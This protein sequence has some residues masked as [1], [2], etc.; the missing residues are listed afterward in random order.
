MRTF[1]PL[2]LCLLGTPLLAQ[3]TNLTRT[4]RTIDFEERRLGNDEDLPMNFVKVEGAGFPHYLSG[5]LAI[6]RA[7]SPGHSFRFDLNGGSLLY[8]Y[9][10]KQI[11][12]TPGACYRVETYVQTT[13]MEHARARVSAYYVD[14]LARP[15]PTSLRHSDLFAASSQWDKDWHKLALD[16]P[17]APP[18]AAYLVL[19]LALLQPQI[20]ATSTLGDRTL[21]PQDIH[22]T[23]WFD[24]ISI[25]HI[26][27]V[28]LSSG[29]PGNIFRRSEPIA[30]SMDINDAF[31]EDLSTQLFVRDAFGKTVYQRSGTQL[32]ADDVHATHQR[33]S[34]PLP[35]LP[36]GWYEIATT[37]VSQGQPLDVQTLRVVRLPD[38]APPT[39]PD[40]RFGLIA[41]DLP[42]EKWP[43]LGTLLPHLGVGRV[44]LGV[45]SRTADAE[46]ADPEAFDATLAKLR[47]LDIHPTACLLELPPSL[48]KKLGG[49]VV[50]SDGPTPGGS[51]LRILKAAK[52]SDW[53]APLEDLLARHASHLDRWQLG[54]DG[55][56]AFVTLSG[57]R[58]VYAKVRAEFT[59]LIQHPDLAMPW[60]AWYE[61]D[62]ASMPATVALSV[63]ATVLPPQ[64]P[65]YTQ[66]LRPAGEH[67]HLSLSLQLLDREHYGRDVQVRDLAQR[68]IFALA[69]GA[70][71][72][73]LPA[74][75][76]H[77]E[78]PDDL[79]PIVHTLFTTLGKA[80]YVG[81]VPVADNVEAFLF[82]KSG[83][84]ILALWDN[85]RS[86]A[87]VHSLPINLGDDPHMTDIYGND[88]PLLRTADDPNT[89][90]VQ[91]V[92][93][94]M[95]AFLTNIDG[96]LAQFRAS[97]SLDNPLIESTFAAHTRRL[98]FKNTYPVTITGSLKI[99]PPEGW[100]ITPSVQTIN[101]AAGESFDREITIEFPVSSTAGARALGFDFVIQ[102][103]KPNSVHFHMPLTVKLG[104][105]D[106]GMQTIAMR[107]GDV[108]LIQQII[109]NYSDHPVDYNAFAMLPGQQRQER[110]V[111]TLRPGE[112][113]VKR[114]RFVNVPA[115]KGLKAR[116]GI[117]EID[118]SRLLNDEVEIP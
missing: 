62:P 61:L 12:V 9:D 103:D 23:A 111:T 82:D 70:D 47:D 81:R 85:G 118:G 115:T 93:G 50:G 95:P 13:P 79:F 2:I 3:P 46:R 27:R 75:F 41:T 37:L 108:V 92:V 101:L 102:A 68:V 100:T 58:T 110:L 40:D 59:T 89:G 5:K 67:R 14:E 33:L 60:P 7:R 8:R 71:R 107:N 87:G 45:W 116:V 98:R 69:S 77:A 28:R 74:P 112:A 32:T 43:A 109:Q 16:L 66:D 26:P 56:D 86:A 10:P 114:F 57:M 48:S 91:L 64:L 80:R 15:M 49:P 63:P 99:K 76:D 39:V 44:K 18:E 29:H 25:S 97:V 36:P 30:F 106:V 22:G 31:I 117:K 55:S 72:I 4:L 21:F 73:D 53:Q 113:T 105:S 104:L 19:E 42:F 24:D 83:S 1:L 96:F 35:D 78:Q 17:A 94:P 88:I 54:A 20:H 52:D 84:G 90:N 6:D 11:K 51:W 65:L 38:D 34:I